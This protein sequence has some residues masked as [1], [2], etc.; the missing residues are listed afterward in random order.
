M[1]VKDGEGSEAW[2]G[3]LAKGYLR[4]GESPVLSSCF[5]HHIP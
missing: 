1:E 4:G 2:T 5:L 3:F